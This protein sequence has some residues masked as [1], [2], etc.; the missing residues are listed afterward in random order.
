MTL[1]QI[2]FLIRIGEHKRIR[3]FPL[4]RGFPSSISAMMQ[5]TDQIST[6]EQERN[7]TE[8]TVSL[9]VSQLN[10]AAPWWTF[11]A[12]TTRRV[13]CLQVPLRVNASHCRLTRLCVVHPVEDDLW[14]AV[15]ARHH[16]ARHLRVGLPR[17]PKVKDL[18]E[19]ADTQGIEPLTWTD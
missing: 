13:Q 17:Q 6:V 3:S 16:V 2:T 7:Q 14:S 10:S 1:S 9:V 15:P 19:R 8:N 18:K 12:R 4:K 11:N 5:P